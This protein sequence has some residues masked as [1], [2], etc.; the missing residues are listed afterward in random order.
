LQIKRCPLK[1]ALELS[2]AKNNPW[3]M[4]RASSTLPIFSDIPTAVS[5][6]SSENQA[7]D[8]LFFFHPC[9]NEEL[10]KTF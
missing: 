1:L 6:L 5:L 8:G 10:W 3:L 9:R 4:C 2:A 7:N